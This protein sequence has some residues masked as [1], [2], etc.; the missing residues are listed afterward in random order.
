MPPVQMTRAEYEAKYGKAPVVASSAPVK[1][2]RAEYE[3][4][5]G[6]PEKTTLNPYTNTPVLGQ[7]SNFGIGAG[8][9]IGRTVAG[10]PE[11]VSRLIGGA[12]KLVGMKGL[13]ESFTRNADTM[14]KT[15]DAILAKPFEKSLD[16]FSGQAGTMT[17]YVAPFFL[18]GGISSPGTPIL[19]RLSTGLKGAGIDTLTGLAQTGGDVKAGGA[20]GLTSLVANT[21]VPGSGGFISRT[22]KG[23][24]PGYVGDVSQG[25]AGQRGEDRTGSSAFIPG[26]GTASAGMLAGISTKLSPEYKAYRNNEIIKNRADE[27]LKI[28]NNYVKTRKNL[29]FSKDKNFASRTRIASTDVL[30]NSVDEGGLI[31]TKGNGGAIDQYKAM[32]LDGMEGVVRK[33]LVNEGATVSPDIVESYLVDKL[34]KSGLEGKALKNALSGVDD[35]IAGLMLRANPEGEIPLAIIHD[36]KISTTNGINY[37]TEPHVKTGAK[38]VASAY[39][40]LI[41]QNSKRPIEAVNKELQKYLQDIALLESLDGRKVAGGKL[42]KYFAQISGNIIGGAAG[43]VGGPVGSSIGAI[44]GGEVG[45]KIKGNILSKTLG[46][47]TGNTVPKNQVLED[48]LQRSKAT[49]YSNNLGNRNTQYNP[50]K[51]SATNVI[52]QSIPTKPIAGKPMTKLAQEID[53]QKIALEF[54]E[55][56]LDSH[57]GKEM[58]RHMATRGEFKGEL[59]EEFGNQG[60]SHTQWGFETFED[61]RQGWKDYRKLKKEVEDRKKYINALRSGS[62]K[63]DE[64][65]GYT[66]ENIANDMPTDWTQGKAKLG[67]V[68]GAGIGSQLGWE[69]NKDGKWHYNPAKGALGALGGGALGA[70]APK[71]AEM[72]KNTPNKQGGFAALPGGKESLGDA[73][74]RRLNEEV[75]KERGMET[76]PNGMLRKIG[77]K[78]DDLTIEAK[79]YKTAEEFANKVPSDV[80]DK[81]REQGIRGGEQRMKFWEDVM[82]KQTGTTYQMSHR[83]TEGVRAFDLTEKVDGENM[84]PKDMYTQWYGS[85][86]TKSDLESIAVL[87]KIKGNPEADV[88]IYRASPKE[89]FNNGDWVSF[90]KSYAQEHATGN[91]TKVYSK[92]VKAKDVKWAMDDINEFGYYPEASFS[93]K[94]KRIMNMRK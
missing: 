41:E 32:T 59:P 58:W 23:T 11:G 45:G 83:P 2:T 17:G 88:T 73:K 64:P 51:T 84:I 82:G 44:L 50:I 31:R 61:A 1:M 74:Y 20:T 56:A 47:V 38:S 79:K 19:A 43:A 72:Y 85:R 4:K 25:L 91:N 42:G 39:K 60:Q 57:P 36:A 22:A 66:Q 12:S 6:T 16:T 71:G 37:A 89:S 9:A 63:I 27:I 7:L 62:V 69:K 46:G 75:W 65:N 18:S 49:P 70:V 35:E 54:A 48:A 78:V 92:T 81:L 13:G 3:A 14:K 21:V 68:L 76:L 94:V 86:G 10:I 40:T 77:E 28:E 90:S 67:T 34:M 30:A 55:D 53:Q 26:L 24:I 93:P 29:D 80:L 5:Y 8:S 33:D 15:S 52:P 87:K